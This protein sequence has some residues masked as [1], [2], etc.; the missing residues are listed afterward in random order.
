M[1]YLQDVERQ[2][3]QLLIEYSEEVVSDEE[4]TDFVKAKVVASYHNGQRDHN[5][6]RRRKH[7]AASTEPAA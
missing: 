6:P 2:F 4:L 5:K 7:N 1:T 3:R